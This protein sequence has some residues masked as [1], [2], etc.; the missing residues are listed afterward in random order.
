[1]ITLAMCADGKP[2]LPLRPRDNFCHQINSNCWPSF[3]LSNRMRL[4]GCGA[5]RF[6]KTAFPTTASTSP[7][8]W[9]TGSLRPLISF[10][11]M[12]VLIR[13][14]TFPGKECLVPEVHWVIQHCHPCQV[15]DQKAQ[16]Q[17]DVY[18][19][20]VQAGAPFQV[21]SMDILAF[22]SSKG[23]K[24]LLTLKDVFSKWFEA[25]LLS[26]TTS[27]KVLRTLQMLYAW[28]GHTLQ[29]HTDN[30]TYFKSQ[31]MQ[32]A[33]RRAG[34]RLT[35]TPMYNP[36]SNSVEQVHRDFN[37]MLRV[38]CHQHAADLEEVLPAALLALRSA[39]HESTG[40]T[41]LCLHLWERTSNPLG[42]AVPFPRHPFGCPQL[43]PPTGGS[44]IQGSPA[45]PSSTRPLHSAQRSPVWE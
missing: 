39:V 1:M 20:S 15:E 37:V 41:T 42:Y 5:I 4:P 26:N 31:M 38:L 36:Q 29:I 19:P 7:M 9:V 24:Y 11:N 44:P 25:I 34:I 12:R 27:D 8:H 28:F 17:K 22:V 18:H 13:P 40:V 45:R 23:H 3:L 14:L 2:N 10:S 43:R 6:K 35:F 21:W 30:S 33:F 16:K 32:E